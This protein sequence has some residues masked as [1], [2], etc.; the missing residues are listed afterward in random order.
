LYDLTPQIAACDLHP[1]YRTTQFAH[2]TGLRVIP[3]QHHYAH[4]LACMAENRMCAPVLGV[5]WDGTGFGTDR[6]VWGGEWLLVDEKSF[7]RAAHLDTFRLPGGEK[8]VKEPRRSALGILYAVYGEGAF[9]MT[10]LA[11]LES[12]SILERDVLRQALA[13]ELNAPVTSSMGRLFDAVAALVGLQQFSSYEGQAAMALEFALDGTNNDE[14]YPFVMIDLTSDEGASGRI[15]D[16]KPMI[17][18]LLNDVRQKVQT[19]IIS[20]K[21]HNTLAETIVAVAQSVGTEQV[22]LS[23]GCFQNKALL[24]RAVDRLRGA[25]FRPYWPRLVPPNDGGIALGQIVAALREM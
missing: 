8:A 17:R 24:E 6:T 11:P 20:A 4:V 9:D 12:F 19:G 18:E 15:I 1:D 3:V 25:G 5:S 16:W 13:H 23:G 21:F 14:S 22:A 10:D 2:E 7:T